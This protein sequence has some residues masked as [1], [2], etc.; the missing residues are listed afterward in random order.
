MVSDGLDPWLRDQDKS[1]Q[2]G[3]Y[4]NAPGPPLLTD[5]FLP[6]EDAWPH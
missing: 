3:A 4:Q 1:M 6:P 5:P 2:Y